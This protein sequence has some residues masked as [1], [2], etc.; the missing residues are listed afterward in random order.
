MSELSP[1]ALRVLEEGV[2]LV[3][4]ENPQSVVVW[5]AAWPNGWA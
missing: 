2:G 1:A 5:S 4:P 3:D